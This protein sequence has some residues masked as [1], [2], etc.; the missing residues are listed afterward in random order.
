MPHTLRDL[1]P[2]DETIAALHMLLGFDDDLAGEAT[3]TSNRITGLLTAIHPSLE[4][5][6]PLIHHPA[7]LDLLEHYGSPTALGQPSIE[8]SPKLYGPA[9]HAWPNAWPPRSAPP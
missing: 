8:R 4:R 7:V 9:P 6:G 5:I 1:E 2:D 3:C